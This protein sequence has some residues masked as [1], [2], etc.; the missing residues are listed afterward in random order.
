[1]EKPHREKGPRG[2]NPIG[3][4]GSGRTAQP[5]GTPG[6]SAPWVTGGQQPGGFRA[7][8]SPMGLWGFSSWDETPKATGGGKRDR[9]GFGGG[10]ESDC[11]GVGGD[12]LGCWMWGSGGSSV[13]FGVA[14]VGSSVERRGSGCFIWDS[15]CSIWGA[16]RYMGRSELDMGHW[17]LYGAFRAGCGVLG[18]LWGSFVG[19]PP[20]V[21]SALMGFWPLSGAGCCL[22]G[23]GAA[24][25]GFPSPPPPIFPMAPPPPLPP[26]PSHN[27]PTSPITP[28]P[29]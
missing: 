12:L 7:P 22:G 21:L 4:R 8:H 18:V 23:L 10:G 29:P 3:K 13:G 16:G 24:L 6:P 27:V 11:C 25:W 14:R 20:G 15:R 17:A 2:E 26:L 28:H 19:C 1:M 5:H 9:K